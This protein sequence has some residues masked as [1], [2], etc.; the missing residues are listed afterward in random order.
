LAKAIVIYELTDYKVQIENRGLTLIL[1]DSS[2][3][4]LDAEFAGD[5]IYLVAAEVSD[6]PE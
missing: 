6:V 3:G 1:N 2:L 5:K 4:L